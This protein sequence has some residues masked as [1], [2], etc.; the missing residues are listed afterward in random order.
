MLRARVLTAVFA[1]FVVAWLVATSLLFVW[2]GE[3]TVTQSEP[4]E[5]TLW[6]RSRDFDWGD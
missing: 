1:A 2:P 6:T 4:G 3:D 5:D